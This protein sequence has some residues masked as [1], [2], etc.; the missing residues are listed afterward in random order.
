MIITNT[1]S[2]LMRLFYHMRGTSVGY[3]RNARQPYTCEQLR[4]IRKKNGI[5][6]PPIV[7]NYR[8]KLKHLKEFYGV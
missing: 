3:K 1:V 2:Y 6:R 5:G 8:K 7:N 4:E